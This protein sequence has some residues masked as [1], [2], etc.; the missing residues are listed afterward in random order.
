MSSKNFFMNDLHRSAANLTN[1]Y[2]FTQA[3]TDQEIE[4]IKTM[5]SNYPKVPAKT[6]AGDGVISDYRKSEVCWIPENNES[7]WL[8]MK[9]ADYA[10]TA[11]KAM[12]NFDIWGFPDELQYTFYYG[13]GGHYD[14]HMDVGPNMA[15]R[16]LS[17]VLQLTGPEEYSGGDLQV[18]TGGYVSTVPKEKGL[19]CFFPS[20]LLHRVTPTLGGTRISLVTWLGGNT[21]R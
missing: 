20:Y 5:S 13:D 6:E 11:N 19:I 12:W 4:A 16:K 1:Y 2:Y 15:N 7:N 3:F 10:N 18:N 9:I 14:W 21:F 17:M 8:Y